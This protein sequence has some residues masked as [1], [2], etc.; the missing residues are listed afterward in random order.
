MEIKNA[1]NNKLSINPSKSL[2]KNYSYYLYKPEL[3][4]TAS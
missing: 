2:D 3:K 1:N 4:K